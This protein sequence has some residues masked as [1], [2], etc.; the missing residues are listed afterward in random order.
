MAFHRVSTLGAEARF[1]WI[2]T[3]LC[4]SAGLRSEECGRI[5][6]QCVTGETGVVRLRSMGVEERRHR[7]TGRHGG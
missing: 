3:W 1:V 7:T 5:G 6:E 2:S 4:W